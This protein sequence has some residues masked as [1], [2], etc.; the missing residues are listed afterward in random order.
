[1]FAELVTATPKP[2]V[3]TIVDV[4]V[5]KTLFG[6]ILP[7]RDAAFVVRPHTAGA[8][9]KAAYDA[10]ALGK[11]IGLA[12]SNVDVGLEEVERLQL[13]YGGSLVQYGVDLG[14]RWVKKT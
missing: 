12:R 8:T 14:D 2:F 11:N 1:M 5:P 10:L 9:A 6:R 4:V 7:T 3:R 13:E